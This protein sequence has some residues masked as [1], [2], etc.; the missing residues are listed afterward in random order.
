MGVTY[1]AM[2]RT[3]KES[4]NEYTCIYNYNLDVKGQITYHVQKGHSWQSLGKEK[5]NRMKL[6][7]CENLGTSPPIFT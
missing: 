4:E 1:F 6:E 3:R 5:L 2:Q 7:V